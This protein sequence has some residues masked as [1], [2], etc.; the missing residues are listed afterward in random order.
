MDVGPALGCPPW[1][2][3]SP[4][5]HSLKPGWV[6]FPFH[7]DGPVLEPQAA[8]HREGSAQEEKPVSSQQSCSA[9][10]GG[11]LLQRRIPTTPSLCGVRPPGLQPGG[12]PMV[13]PADS[14]PLV[15]RSHGQNYLLPL[16][17]SQSLWVSS[18]WEMGVQG[19]TGFPLS[20]GQATALTLPAQISGHTSPQ[21]TYRV[22]A[23]RKS[24][25]LSVSQASRCLCSPAVS[26]MSDFL[27]PHGL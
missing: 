21:G 6:C 15:H 4:L 25:R 26:G 27:L 8:W 22:T 1:P 11:W 17:G 13:S 19:S 24:D 23:P 5:P 7:V 9:P 12:V 14:Q 20:V 3:G 16:S 18:A 2:V 10:T